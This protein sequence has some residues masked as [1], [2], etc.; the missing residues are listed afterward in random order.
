M[1]NLS[2]L[3]FKMLK[4]KGKNSLRIPVT[5]SYL[6]LPKEYEKN[7]ILYDIG[8]KKVKEFDVGLTSVEKLD[9]AQ[10]LNQLNIKP[11]NLKKGCWY[12]AVHKSWSYKFKVLK[13]W[14]WGDCVKIDIHHWNGNVTHE[15]V[16]NAAENVRHTKWGKL[17]CILPL[18]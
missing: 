15:V 6:I 16:R 5:H 18:K 3:S 17:V 10:M 1:E 2:N 11:D 4:I 13:V 12:I 7:L 14:S 8:S 9:G